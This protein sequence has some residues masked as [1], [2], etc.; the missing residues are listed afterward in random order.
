MKEERKYVHRVVIDLDK[1]LQVFR[2]DDDFSNNKAKPHNTVTHDNECHPYLGVGR[3]N[4]TLSTFSQP[5][6]QAFLWCFLH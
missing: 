4:E 5:T 1:K 6:K 2:K 3:I